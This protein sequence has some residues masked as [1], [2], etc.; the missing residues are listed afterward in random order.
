[1]CLQIC[2]WVPQDWTSSSGDIAYGSASDNGP[3]VSYVSLGDLFTCNDCGRSWPE[4]GVAYVVGEGSTAFRMSWGEAG[5][6]DE[7]WYPWHAGLIYLR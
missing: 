2:Y 1:M 4:P 7:G 6:Q 5:G 3:V